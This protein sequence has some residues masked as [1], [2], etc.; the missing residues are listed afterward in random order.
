MYISINAPNAV[1]YLSIMVN[2]LSETTIGV[3]SRGTNSKNLAR[4]FCSNCNVMLQ[5]SLI[6]EI[7]A[8]PGF[9]NKNAVCFHCGI[10][11]ADIIE[12][13]QTVGYIEAKVKETPDWSLHPPVVLNP[14][15]TFPGQ[16]SK[17]NRLSRLK[18]NKKV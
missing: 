2:R 5:N 14:D 9:P 18:E 13:E 11:N 7:I 6:D 3:I 15:E 16:N 17:G 8:V 12:R 10:E 4:K 1:V